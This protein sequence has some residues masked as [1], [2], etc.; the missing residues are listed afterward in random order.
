MQ[1]IPPLSHRIKL[2]YPVFHRK[3][4]AFADVS[5]LNARV[6]AV[7][8]NRSSPEPHRIPR[9]LLRQPSTFLRIAKIAE[10]LQ[11][12]LRRN[13][14]LMPRRRAAPAPA[15]S[16]RKPPRMHPRSVLELLHRH[17]KWTRHD[18]PSL[19]HKTLSRT[20]HSTHHAHASQCQIS[21][22][23]T[24]KCSTLPYGNIFREL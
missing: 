2:K 1:L 15:T 8:K 19:Y 13:L 14:A 20:A 9:P 6:I 17:E 11:L 3:M 18:R 4:S 22:A 16:Q 5:N 12:L 23:K 10:L 21:R 7:I 24:A